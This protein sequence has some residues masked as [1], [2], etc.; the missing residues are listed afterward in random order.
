MKKHIIVLSI[1]FYLPLGNLF[2]QDAT[3]EETMN[4]IGSK[5]MDKGIWYSRNQSNPRTCES[6]DHH[7]TNLKSIKLSYKTI[8]FTN[9]CTGAVCEL[10]LGRV[11]SIDLEGVK[12]KLSSTQRFVWVTK[13]DNNVQVDR[14]TVVT[15]AYG[16]TDAPRLLKAF[17]HLF[18][19]LEINLPGDKF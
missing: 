1:C 5:T 10:N 14:P 7:F 15:I 16:E 4:F 13:D 6:L 19:L 9:D 11:N 12:I 3:L 18:K 2:A 8:V 17:K